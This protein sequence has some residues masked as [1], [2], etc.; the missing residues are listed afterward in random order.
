MPYIS[1]VPAIRSPWGVD[2]FDYQIS[3]D[4]DVRS[5]DLLRVPFRK[6]STPALVVSTSPTSDFADRTTLV[7][8]TTPLLRF[9]AWIVPLLDAA[10]RRSFCS[11]PT[12]LQSWLRDVPKRAV[13]IGAVPVSDTSHRADVTEC[14]ADRGARVLDIVSKSRGRTLVLTPWKH[15]ADAYARMLQGDVL[16]ADLA[17]GSAWNAWTRFACSDRSVLVATRIGAWLVACADTV[18]IDEPEND[19]FKQDELTPRL[20]ARWLVDEA[21]TL[22]PNLSIHR[23]ST[24]PPLSIQAHGDATAPTISPRVSFEP[25]HR[26]T[27][28]S[29]DAITSAALTAIEDAVAKK[30]SVVVLHPIA[31]ERGRI[32]CRECGWSATC[33]SCGFPLSRESTV[34]RCRRCGKTEPLIAE[35]PT[36]GGTDLSKSRPGKDRVARILA[37]RFP[38][39]NVRVLD[40]QDWH[41]S[42]FPSGTLMVVTDLALV[43]GYAEDIRRRERLVIAWRRL[44]AAAE[45][46][47]ADL[48]VQASEEL[49]LDAKK[50]LTSEGLL[51]AWDAEWKDRER[52]GYPPA[53]PLVKLLIDGTEEAANVLSQKAGASLPDWAIRGPYPVP[54][55]STSRK[56]RFSINLLPPLNIDEATISACLEPFARAA[57][58][59]LDPIAFFS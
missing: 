48:I 51:A 50:W 20:D 26:E 15:R 32:A 14:R 59:D 57:I 30:R 18:V 22:R 4:A 39:S 43:G 7:T 29:V 36:C 56:T 1:V 54:F 31:G 3:D 6:R 28:S 35:C 38:S 46:T 17:A 23:I 45:Q 21:N 37:E 9:P 5:G 8:D 27:R 34:A 44:A 58:I 25:V 40:L 16:H 55:R 19:D 52:F 41:T 13:Q 47:G 2:V 12:V 11:R 53:I 42:S 33:A 10:S 24:T 49:L